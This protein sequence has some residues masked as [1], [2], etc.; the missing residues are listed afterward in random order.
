MWQPKLIMDDDRTLPHS[1]V[2]RVKHRLV[3]TPKIPIC[4][5]SDILDSCTGSPDSSHSLNQDQL[6]EGV[7]DESS[8]SSNDATS[9]PLEER[10]R[11]AAAQQCC[12]NALIFKRK[13]LPDDVFVRGSTSSAPIIIDRNA[14]QSALLQPAPAAVTG[15]EIVPWKP[16]FDVLALQLWPAVVKSRREANARAT[17]VPSGPVI[18]L[19]PPPQFEFQSQQIRPS[20]SLTQGQKSKAANEKKTL[21]LPTTISES[22]ASTPL[23]QSTV[24]R[25]SRRTA[26]LDGFCPVRLSAN[27]SK[28]RKIAVVQ[29]NESTGEV[30]PVDIFVLQGWG[31]DC[32]VAPSELTEDTLLQ[33]P[34]GQVPNEDHAN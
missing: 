30:A 28:K 3:W 2:T 1:H 26:K 13:D 10:A 34:I 27:P 24:R 22:S 8:S 29:I 11:F 4:K 9:A 12:A 33:A 20:P 6:F 7:V 15:M 23:V 16:V 25:S 31:I 5:A 14:M 21:A 19:G 32:G 18:L 17:V